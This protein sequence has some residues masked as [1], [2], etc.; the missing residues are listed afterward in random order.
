MAAPRTWALSST[1]RPPRTRATR[2][3][4]DAWPAPRSRRLSRLARP[5]DAAEFN[6][7]ASAAGNSRRPAICDRLKRAAACSAL[8]SAD[9]ALDQQR[10]IGRLAQLAER[11]DAPRRERCRLVVAAQQF[12]HGRPGG[13]VAAIG[14]GAEQRRPG[15]RRRAWAIGPQTT[16]LPPVLALRCAPGPG[17]PRGI[18]CPGRRSARRPSAAARWACSSAGPAVAPPDRPTARRKPSNRITIRRNMPQSP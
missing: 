4:P 17:R 8:E 1:R 9:R 5:V 6:S 10:Q 7:A 2:P 18:P 15:P 13:R 11:G 3:W 16:S 12:E 14:Q